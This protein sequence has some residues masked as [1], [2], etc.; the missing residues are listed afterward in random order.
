M[1]LFMTEERALRLFAAC[2]RRQSFTPMLRWLHKKASYTAF[3]RFY[4]SSGKDGVARLLGEKE[5]EL[6][7]LP[8]PNR[9]F[10][11]FMMVKHDLIGNRAESCAVLTRADPW[12]TEGIVRI[13]CTPLHIKDIRVLNPADCQYTRGEEET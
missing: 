4:V 11:G 3:N 10:R 9:A 6:Q 2:Y 7:A 1:G 8:R 13:K 12:Q 5:T